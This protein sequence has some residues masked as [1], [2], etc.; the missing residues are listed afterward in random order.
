M[1]AHNKEIT[2]L[3]RSL[4]KIKGITYLEYPLEHGTIKISYA[5]SEI[6]HKSP[7]DT[8]PEQDITISPGTHITSPAS[9]KNLSKEEE[10]LLYWSSR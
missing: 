4:S 2:Q 9:P 7:G 5:N 1:N 8:N 10:E 6:S 3:I